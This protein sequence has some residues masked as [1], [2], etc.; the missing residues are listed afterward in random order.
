M[1][2]HIFG[3]RHHGPGCAR[4]LRAALAALEPDIVL[5]E[6]PPDAEAILPLLAREGMEP[7]VAML[8]YVPDAPHRAVYYPFTAFSPEWQALTYALGRGIPARFMDLP[9]ALQMAATPDGPPDIE[10]QEAAA[11]AVPLAPPVEER[12]SDGNADEADQPAERALRDDPIGLLAEAAGYRDHELWWERQIEQRVGA[13]DLFEGIMEAMT[14]LRAEAGPPP[15]DEARREAHMRQTIRAAEAAGFAR[16][17]VVCGAWHAPALAHRE[18]AAGDAMLLAELPRTE[19]VA[20]WIPWTNSRLASRTGYGAGIA[21]PGWYAHLW[22]APDRVSVRWLAHVARLLRAEDLEASSA[23]VI[24]AA[25]LADTLAAL[26]ELPMPG[27][28]E[29]NEAALTVLC[30]GD[31]T[32]MRLIREQLEIGEAMGAVPPET[33]GVPLQRDLERW[34]RT[35]G[36]LPSAAIATV[37]V[38]LRKDRDRVKSQLLHRLRLLDIPWGTPQRVGGRKLGTFHELWQVQW[39]VEFAVKLIEANIWGNTI[40]TAAT[41]FVRHQADAERELPGLTGLLDGVML[42]DLP[43]AADYLLQRI[44]AQAAVAADVR[45]LMDALPPLARVARYGDV[46]QTQSEHVMPI[47]EGLFARV[48]V[49]LPGASGALDDDAAH[50]LVASIDHVQESLSLLDRTDLNDTWHDLLARLIARDGAHGLVRGRACRL[51]LEQRMLDDVELQRLARLA[52]APVVAADQAGAWVEGLL[53]GSGLLLLHQDGLWLA[54][55]AWLRDLAPETFVA[56]LPLLRRTFASFPAPERRQMGERLKHMDRLA[57][58]SGERAARV[59]DAAVSLAGID[60]ARADLVLPV[61]AQV[62]GVEA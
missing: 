11:A 61:L 42:A 60:R 17:A 7:P 19:V 14:A 54:L 6:G 49:G 9:Q 12:G 32:P 38:D 51:L 27:I 34:Q 16:I 45:H 28:A 31:A 35:L 26:R 8:L 47:I 24:E 56:L 20:T 39:Q 33:P 36:L 41:G 4:S 23:S 29:L 53:H 5:V 59:A 55:D 48:V 50:Q 1:S 40:E 25:R 37:D 13:S 30:H 2:A 18:D 21:S 57:S 3:I 10:A 43:Q 15:D 44:S 62:M 46:R 22:A 58:A 52:L